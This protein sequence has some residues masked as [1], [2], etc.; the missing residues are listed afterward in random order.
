MTIEFAGNGLDTRAILD[1]GACLGTKRLPQDDSL[2][3]PVC[4][5]QVQQRPQD[6]QE[7]TEPMSPHRLSLASFF[8]S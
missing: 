3:Q 5:V 8:I 4:C 7:T 1:L 2:G 6:N